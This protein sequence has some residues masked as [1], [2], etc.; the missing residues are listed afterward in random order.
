MRKMLI[1]VVASMLC[2]PTATALGNDGRVDIDFGRGGELPVPVAGY[3]A[4]G[5]KLLSDGRIVLL[6]GKALRVLLPS[7]KGDATVGKGGAFPVVPPSEGDCGI[8]IV[9]RDALGRLAGV[10][11]CSFPDEPVRQEYPQNY[12][13]KLLV[14]RW[15][16]AGVLDRSFGG[17]DGMVV[18]DFGL[19]PAAPGLLPE[20]RADEAAFDAFGRIVVA[21]E[22]AAGF[23]PIKTERLQP[24]YEPFVA[25][26]TPEGEVDRSLGDSGAL[27]VSGLGR[28]EGMVTD[29]HGGVLLS[30]LHD[31]DTSLL[32]IGPDGKADGSFGEGGFR[33][34]ALGR[35]LRQYPFGLLGRD[36]SG[37]VVFSAKVAGYKKRHL[38][39]GVALKRLNPDGSLDRTLGQNGVFTARFRRMLYS[40]EVLDDQG[41]VLVAMAIRPRNPGELRTAEIIGISLARLLPDG[42]LDRSFGRRGFVRIPFDPKRDVDLER[43]QVSGEVAL[44]SKDRCDPGEH[45]HPVLIRVDLGPQ[46]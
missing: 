14:E 16:P 30:Y 40:A 7:G 41:R 20:L 23:A 28:N 36:P 27:G 31:Y 1:L 34:L 2:G 12:P 18:S 38:R 9:I 43:L 46:T 13:G 26:L 11:R 3:S 29:S 25:R 10:G 22:R 21:G 19:P 15:T 6:E 4:P 45:C 39:N 35:G 17:G 8:G 33:K 24:Y 44:I 32:R 37:R 5:V 42:E